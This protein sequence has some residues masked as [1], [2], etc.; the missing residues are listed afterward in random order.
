[1]L[2]PVG[3]VAEN[4][5]DPFEDLGRFAGQ[6]LERVESAGAGVAGLFGDAVGLAE[7]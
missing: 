2:R 4:L 5:L 6:A 3:H 1:M 7:R